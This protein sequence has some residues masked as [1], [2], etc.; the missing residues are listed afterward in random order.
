[1]T[2]AEHDASTPKLIAFVVGLIATTALIIHAREYPVL[3]F[4]DAF[5]SLR[6]AQRLLEGHG[7]T[8]T[9]GPPV[10]G[11][12]NLLWVLGCALL[13]AV[14]VDLLDT[15]VILGVGSAIATIAAMVYAFP[16]HAWSKSVPAFAGA[17]F[18]AL[19][20]PIA[21]WAVAGLEGCLVGA[22]LACSLVLLRP[23]VDGDADGWKSAL[24]PGIPLALLC[25]TRPDGPL[26]VVIIC[27]FLLVQARS[28]SAVGRAIAVGALPALATLGQ[29]AFRLTYYGDWLPNTAR[30]K[31]AFTAARVESGT[32]CVATAGL[33]SYALW[34]PAIL[35][36]YVAWRDAQRRPRILLMV[37]LVVAWTTYAATIVC[38]PY[39]YR[40]L[41][42]SYV[43]LA[44]LV[45]EALDW[46]QERGRAA[47]V[48][49]W[50][51][52][53]ALLFSFGRSQ[54]ADKNIILR[55]Q[56]K[57]PVVVKAASVGNTLREAFAERNPLV[58]V[59]AAGA[60]PFYSGLRSLDML[61]LADAHIARH[62]GESFG[63]GEQGHELGDGAYVLSR[64]PDIIVAHRLGSHRLAYVGG[65]EMN[66][67]P[68]FRQLYRRV[69]IRGEH[70]VP[71]SFFI[72]CRLDGR[73]GVQRSEDLVTIPGYLFA[74]DKGTEAQLDAAKT[75]GTR[76]LQGTEAPLDGLELPAGTWHLTAVGTGPFRLSA[77]PQSGRAIATQASDGSELLLEK[78]G[79]VDIR[80]LASAPAFLTEV[81]ARRVDRNPTHVDP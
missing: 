21:I 57:P 81:V 34:V 58:A 55:Q 62:R 66:A 74:K 52:T 45:A 54:Q 38:Q 60:I 30:A 10:E 13:G 40:M 72:F 19:A 48:V 43:L 65:R 64:E 6:Y 12:S 70:P 42:P 71:T 61:G 33:S 63:Q 59:D 50:L 69:R 76:F 53:L 56:S 26:L 73:V 22:L 18:I 17:M 31:V 1:M 27:T 51:A 47:N 23:V 77:R 28:R 3:V 9:E 25:L 41:I 67:D 78:P 7:L 14:G 46:I 5:I 15:P 75:L 80:V 20:G 37:T 35:A 2:T 11:Y 24:R 44:F 16:P 29:L 36:L 32:Q 49:A 4:D 8:W 79:L 68:R 39:G